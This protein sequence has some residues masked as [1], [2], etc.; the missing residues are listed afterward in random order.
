M[1]IKILENKLQTILEDDNFKITKENIVEKIKKLLEEK[2]RKFALVNEATTDME[3]YIDNNIEL[4]T[5]E[6]IVIF[7]VAANSIL[8]CLNTE[9]EDDKA[10]LCDLVGELFINQD[11]YDLMKD[12]FPAIKKVVDK[13]NLP[14]C[15]F[16]I[17]SVIDWFE[18]CFDGI[19]TEHIEYESIFE[20]FD[21]EFE[22]FNNL[23]LPD[24]EEIQIVMN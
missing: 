12:S 22:D 8:C 7:K 5:E 23:F 10:R 6:N 17:K 2:L 13:L 3:Y 20:Y 1:N 14:G 9:C 21:K 24:E 19:H 18:E 16:D 11:F 4:F 15:I